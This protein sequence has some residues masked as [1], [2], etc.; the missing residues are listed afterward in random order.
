MTAPLLIQNAAIITE[1]KGIPDGWLYIEAGKI[2]AVNAGTPPTYP[3][4]TVIDADGLTL[5]P[6]YIDL[7]AHGGDGHEAMDATPAALRSIATFYARHGVTGWLPTTWTAPHQATL[8]TLAAIKP[9]V[10]VTTGGAAILGV[11]LEG[12]YLNVERLGAQHGE[13]IRRATRDEALALLDTGIVRLLA[14]AP[15]FNENLWLIDECVRRGITVSAA[16]TD[17]DYA[18]MAAAVERGLSQTTHTFNAMR[19]LHHREPGTVGAALLLDALRCE[20]IP[21]PNHIHPAM[22]QLLY[23]VKGGDGVVII[24]DAVRGAG[25]PDD[26]TY[27]QS[28]GTV[29]IKNGAARLSDGT[30]AGST[31][32]MDAAVRNFVV[33]T[34]AA[35]SEVWRCASLNA[36]RA[37]DLAAHK[38]SIAPGK[39]ADLIL[40][41]AGLNVR[42]T[43]VG[44]EIV[45]QQQK[46]ANNHASGT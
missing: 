41:D 43:L 39:D 28:G 45:Y 21:D 16:H 25:M 31:L 22:Q 42:M 10:G 18:T 35:F 3:D 14:L 2:N 26:T 40:L 37:L 1:N 30:L 20:V 23:K 13:N 19:G 44:G 46:E 33:A 7:H 29:T 15:E 4:S 5:A 38:G 36:A 27:M 12:P 8:A 24:T 17:A 32:T 9:L 6:G 11:H 34:G